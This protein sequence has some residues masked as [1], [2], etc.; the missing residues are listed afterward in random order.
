MARNNHSSRSPRK[1]IPSSHLA[2]NNNV[3]TP[4]RYPGRNR[5]STSSPVSKTTKKSMSGVPANPKLS[6]QQEIELAP[7]KQ[8]KRQEQA[9]AKAAKAE[10]ICVKTVTLKQA[11]VEQQTTAAATEEEDEDDEEEDT[12]N[13]LESFFDNDEPQ[14]GKGSQR[15]KVD[16]DNEENPQ[17]SSS[18]KRGIED[19]DEEDDDII[20]VA[21]IVEEDSDI[22]VEDVTPTTSVTCKRRQSSPEASSLAKRS[23]KEKSSYPRSSTL[24]KRDVG[25]QNAHLSKAVDDTFPED[26]FAFLMQIMENTAYCS[27]SQDETMQAVYQRALEDTTREKLDKI[28]TYISVRLFIYPSIDNSLRLDMP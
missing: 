22:I 25:K 23:R 26:K 19:S 7:L 9:A 11:E 12:F 14:P 5:S 28:M 8:L 17:G 24:T 21:S 2:N 18:V 13:D 4:I 3:A 1:C 16:D 20:S 27:S 10:A 15:C 6:K